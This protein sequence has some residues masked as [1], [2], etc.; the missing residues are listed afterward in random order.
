MK[1]MIEF[2]EQLNNL[3]FGKTLTFRQQHCPLS[4]KKINDQ[5]WLYYEAWSYFLESDFY[6]KNYL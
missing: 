2:I 4:N 1:I 5:N 6:F 3:N